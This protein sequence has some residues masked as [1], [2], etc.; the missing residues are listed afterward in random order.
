M[1]MRVAQRKGKRAA[2][3][4]DDCFVLCSVQDGLDLMAAA[5]YEYDCD[6]III[7]KKY[8]CDDF[9][10]LKTR[11]AGEILQKYTTYEMPIAIVA[12]IANSESK[13]MR[14]FVYESNK[15]K[16]VHFAETEDEAMDWISKI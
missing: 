14:D 2:V 1:K 12:S 16:R 3:V 11:I 4:E 13:S 10:E 7:D 6:N 5:R 9:F 15:G 8:I